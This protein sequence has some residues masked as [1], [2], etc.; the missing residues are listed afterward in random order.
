MIISDSLSAMCE[1]KTCIQ[2][3]WKKLPP[4]MEFLVGIALEIQFY[5]VLFPDTLCLLTC[6]SKDLL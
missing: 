4:L 2:G 1:I 6:S 5:G 3:V